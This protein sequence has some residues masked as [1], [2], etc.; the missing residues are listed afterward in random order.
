MEQLMLCKEEIH[1]VSEKY[2]T[3]DSVDK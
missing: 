3:I 2:G 1:A